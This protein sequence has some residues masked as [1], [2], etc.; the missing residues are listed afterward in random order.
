M[1]SV[2]PCEGPACPNTAS[3]SSR[4]NAGNTSSNSDIAVEWLNSAFR[5]RRSRITA[6][7]AGEIAR[8]APP[9][10]V[11]RALRPKTASNSLNSGSGTTSSNSFNTMSRCKAAFRVN[12]STMMTTSPTGIARVDVPVESKP[13]T[14]TGG[15]SGS[16]TGKIAREEEGELQDV[17]T[18]KCFVSDLSLHLFQRS[19][20][21]LA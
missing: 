18:S 11:V 3:S 9:V 10:P 14:A 16:T 17:D 13:D 7:S 6:T 5:T 19:G 12:L 20:E 4:R 1:L 15:A 8:G 21:T 2:I